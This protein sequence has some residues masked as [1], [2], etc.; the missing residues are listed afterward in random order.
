MVEPSLPGFIIIGAAKAATTW[1]AYQLQQYPC[2]YLPG[3]E[4]HYFSTEFH[5]G[6]NW[7]EQFFADAVDGQIVG[8]KSA[9][10]LAHSEA[11]RRIAQ[12]LP[13]VQII[14]QLRNPIDR[15][16]SDYC[17]FYRRGSVG[18]DPD[19]YLSR[20]KTEIPR[21][22]EDGLYCRHLARFMDFFP[23][24]QLKIILYED[25][26]NQPEVVIR[27]VFRYIG[28]N[29]PVV[30]VTMGKRVNDKAT[31]LLPLALRRLL[32]PVKPLVE[33]WRQRPWFRAVR[34]AL[35]KPLEYPPLSMEMR[36]RLRDYYAED[37]ERLGKLVGRDL[38]SWLKCEEG[39]Q[40]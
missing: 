10:Y 36:L 26:R 6:L 17:M 27:D 38:S 25:I 37:V 16:Y 39:H 5:R 14:A 22:L 29:S 30:P 15:A 20:S 13:Q 8:E 24:E 12:R 2:I 19:H 33:P 11:P 31:P 4:P 18:V 9:D 3:P 35:A 23:R 1:I 28:I 40:A 21:F 34:N 32:R 7:Y